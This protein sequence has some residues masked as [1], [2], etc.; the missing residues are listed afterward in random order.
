[1]GA[2]SDEPVAV[3]CQFGWYIQ[4]G[5]T[6]GDVKANAAINFI[7]MAAVSEIEEFLGIENAGLGP[8][9]CKCISKTQDQLATE[10]MEKSVTRLDDGSYQ[11]GLPWKKSPETLPNN[12]DYAVKRFLN[13]EQQF[14]N[15]PYEWQVYC[16]QMD[17]QIARGVAR[18]IPQSEMDDDIT[19]DRK[20]W[21]LPHFAV[22]KDS[23]TTPVRV[24]YDAKARYKGHS[25]NDYLSK[26][27]NLNND[28]FNVALRFREY[29][30]GIIADISKMF[31][32]VKMT[33]EDARFHRYLH[34]KHPDDPIQVCLSSKQSHLETSHLPLLQL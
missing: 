28:I 1:M 26:G 9:P 19:A 27:N 11:I 29:E 30:V 14:K 6:S 13:L 25:L 24:V 2:K 21:F 17:D 16:K 20:M 34:R 4:G 33:S 3:K 32:A 18:L 5:R 12:Y 23:E 7:Q 22:L 31:Q 10:R 8:R 15:K